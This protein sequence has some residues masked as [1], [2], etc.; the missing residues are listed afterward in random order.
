[1]IKKEGYEYCVY[2][3]TGERKLGCFPTEKA[4]RKRLQ[5]IEHFKKTMESVPEFPQE[6]A[7]YIN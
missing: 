4:A 5:Q 1:M 6:E 7:Y 2:S 3:K